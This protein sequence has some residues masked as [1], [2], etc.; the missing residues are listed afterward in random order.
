MGEV[1]QRNTSLILGIVLSGMICAIA[2]G[3]I[4]FPT[5][6][7]SPTLLQAE[8]MVPAWIITLTVLAIST[9]IAGVVGRFSNAAVGLFVLGCGVFVLAR[10]MGSLEV[11]A[12]GDGALTPLV[13]EAIIW[14]ILLA[15]MS[16]TV[17]RIAGPLPDVEP[18]VFHVHPS[19]Y[20]S[21]E[22]LIQM[23]CGVLMLPVVWL[24]AQSPDKGQVL[25]AAILGG[26]ACGLVG[27][28]MSPHV[29][30]I[31]L[32]ASPCLFGAVG[33]MVGMVMLPGPLVDAYILRSLPAWV[34]PMPVDYA[35]GTLI[36]VSFG[37]GWAKSFLHHEETPA[38]SA[39]PAQSPS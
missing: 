36:G 6:A 34:Q 30:P 22:A 39:S 23:G 4:V 1:I 32:F 33:Y 9:V 29:Q 18:N 28:L 10:R 16:W 14:T 15:G 7:A 12:F 19:P 26:I 11:L 2:A 5:G 27:R 31:L 21:R 24:F 37:L 35:A 13:V 8:S 25:G 20:F 38:P 17:F 3:W